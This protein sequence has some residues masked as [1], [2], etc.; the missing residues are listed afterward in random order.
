VTDIIPREDIAFGQSLS[1]VW[2]RFFEKAFRNLNATAGT[3]TVIQQ[4]VTQIQE[5]PADLSGKQDHSG[6]LDQLTGLLGPGF[7]ERTGGGYV[8]RLLDLSD[9]PADVAVAGDALVF[10]GT[11]WHPGP[12]SGSAVV[13]ISDTPPTSPRVGDLWADSSTGVIYLRYDDGTTVAWVEFGTVGGGDATTVPTVMASG[14]T[15]TVAANTQVLFSMPIDVG[16]ATLDV[17]G[18]LLEVN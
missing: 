15:F 1:P 13:T 7:V 9:I 16:D 10:D 5:N 4:T 3:V 12:V 8:A 6:A 18:Y 2:R 14:Q 17:S 11:A